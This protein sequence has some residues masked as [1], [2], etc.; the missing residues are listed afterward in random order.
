L[1]LSGD[2]RHRRRIRRAGVPVKEAFPR[3]ERLP[4]QYAA[5]FAEYR[6]WLDGQ[7]YTPLQVK[8]AAN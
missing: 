2:V 6:A 7:A 1:Q 3:A 5:S 8:V 4:A